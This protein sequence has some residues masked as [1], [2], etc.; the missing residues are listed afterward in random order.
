METIEI[1]PINQDKELDEALDLWSGVFPKSRAFFE[2]RIRLDP[3]CGDE[4]TWIAR[5]NGK[6]AGA[7]QIFPLLLSYNGLILKCGGI[8]NVAA[9]PEYRGRHLI[10]TILK[11]QTEW[12]AD[13]GYDLSLLFTGINSFYKKEGWHTFRV[14]RLLLNVNELP[15]IEVSHRYKIRDFEERDL[16]QVQHV[17]K[18]F[19]ALQVGSVIRTDEYWH[20]QL[21]WRKERNEKF[22]NAFDEDT[23]VA[24]MRYETTGE[25]R[26]DLVECC[27]LPGHEGA[28]LTLIN[29]I[30]TIGANVQSLCVQFSEQHFLQT[31]FKKWGAHAEAYSGTMWKIVRFQ[32]FC[33]KIQPVLSKRCKPIGDASLLI[34]SGMEE[35][36]IHLEGGAVA[37]ETPGESVICQCLIERKPEDFIMDVLVG[38]SLDQ[39]Q[40]ASLFPKTSY[41]FCQSDRF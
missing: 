14:N 11:H 19:N 26:L 23:L 40:Y 36:V 24:Y 6:L 5:V 16:I 1:R 41:G 3:E 35:A 12:M 29:R 8:G 10:R 37:I 21:T 30:K 2:Q 17:Y 9:L 25:G 33:K 4:T 13:H 28:A 22:L 15:E 20:G 39:E 38:T 27:F 18:V 32:E 31:L 34:R 7:V